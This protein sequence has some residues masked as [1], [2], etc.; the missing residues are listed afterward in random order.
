MSWG[1]IHC[2]CSAMVFTATLKCDSHLLLGAASSSAHHLPTGPSFALFL[3]PAEMHTPPCHLAT[4]M[5]SYHFHTH[6]TPLG[7]PLSLSRSSVRNTGRTDFRPLVR[8]QSSRSPSF[9]GCSVEL[10]QQV[11]SWESRNASSRVLCDSSKNS[12]YVV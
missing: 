5:H 6:I 7:L 4:S 11:P 10:P 1:P 3:A 2:H 8:H 12:V 9:S